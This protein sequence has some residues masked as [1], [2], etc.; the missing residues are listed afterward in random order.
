MK[1][2]IVEAVQN[3]RVSYT[4]LSGFPML[5]YRSTTSLAA[6]PGGTQISWTSS[7]HPKYPMTGWF[8]RGLM[9]RTLSSMVRGLASA[10]E[11]QERRRQ[12]LK[13]AQSGVS[14]K[15]DMPGAPKGVSR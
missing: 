9:N 14:N 5:D 3:E 15:S 4:L 8:W 10:A 7:F 6:V 11:D 2:E 12:I 13:L 1:E